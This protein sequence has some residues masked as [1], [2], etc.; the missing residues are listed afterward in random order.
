MAEIWEERYTNPK[1]KKES[2]KVFEMFQ[3][4]LEQKQ[5]PRSLKQLVADLCFNGDCSKEIQETTE[6]QRKYNSIQRNSSLYDWTDR[7][8]AYDTYW[9]KYNNKLKSEIIADLEV[10]AIQKIIEGI[11]RIEQNHQEFCEEETEMV[12]V[13]DSLQE[14]PIRKTAKIHSDN[15]YANSLKTTFETIYLIKNGGTLKTDNKNRDTVKVSADVKSR[16]DNKTIFDIVDK[17]LSDG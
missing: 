16:V 15:E 3:L 9:R 10:S 12:V 6:F 2:S 4:F 13:G 8:N 11:G 17:E 7:A 1:G 5:R 14:R